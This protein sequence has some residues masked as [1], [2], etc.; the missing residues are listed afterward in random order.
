MVA[1]INIP[2][3]QTTEN[4]EDDGGFMNTVHYLIDKNETPIVS[5]YLSVCNTE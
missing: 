3:F 2:T 5:S 4:K 1:L